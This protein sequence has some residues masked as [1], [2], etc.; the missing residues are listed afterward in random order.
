MFFKR[1]K[2]TNNSEGEGS[3]PESWRADSLLG[4]LRDAEKA[5]RKT[6]DDQ[7]AMV[8]HFEDINKGLGKVNHKLNQLN[9]ELLKANQPQR[10]ERDVTPG[11][12][13][14]AVVW[15]KVP[16]YLE[17]IQLDGEVLS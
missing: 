8:D 1:N 2:Q 15:R 4:M 5:L 14:P 16:A 12:Q 6:A 13:Q 10:K 9:S 3:N 11:K 7:Q 17:G